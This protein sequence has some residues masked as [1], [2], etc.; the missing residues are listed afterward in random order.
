MKGKPINAVIYKIRQS[1]DSLIRKQNRPLQRPIMA[2]SGRKTG[3][4]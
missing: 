4:F 3:S 1:S 2:G